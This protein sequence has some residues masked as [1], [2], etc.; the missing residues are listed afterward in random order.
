MNSV[1]EALSWSRQYDEPRHRKLFEQLIHLVLGGPEGENR[2]RRSVE[3]IHLPFS[4]EEEAWFEAYLT[5]GEGKHLHGAK[6]AYKVR[7]VATGKCN[8][9]AGRPDAYGDKSDH[10]MEWSSL[11]SSYEQGSMTSAR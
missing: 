4:K 8:A 11:G 5:D 7:T 2:A 9:I 3:L 6:D 1:T 10:L